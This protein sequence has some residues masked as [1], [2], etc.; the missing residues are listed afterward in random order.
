[1]SRTTVLFLG[2][3]TKG[4][5]MT[6]MIE[7]PPG[8]F[9]WADIGTDIE[10]AKSFYGPLFGWEAADAGPPEETGGY[11]FF[12]LDGKLVCGYGPQQ[13][14]GPPFWACYVATDD[15]EKPLCQ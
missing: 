4:T 8:V 15:A 7:F 11:G 1:M 2:A 12:T 6:Q 9:S 13:S 14:P 5:D 3:S 10:G